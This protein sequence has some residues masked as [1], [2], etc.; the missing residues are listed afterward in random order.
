MISWML[1]HVVIDKTSMTRM[2]AEIDTFKSKHSLDQL[3]NPGYSPRIL[4]SAIRETFRWATTATTARLATED[5]FLLVAGVQVPIM[6]SEW[7]L[8]DVRAVH[9]NPKVYKD[10]HAYQIDR[11]VNRSSDASPVPKPFPWGQGKHMIHH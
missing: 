1:T 4:E 2:V 9:H 7:I 5:T 3:D 10:P 11:Y 8:G 6:K